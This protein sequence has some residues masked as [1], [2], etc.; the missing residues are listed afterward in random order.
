M[1]IHKI[2]ARLESR[3]QIAEGL[4]I[5]LFSL[6]EDFHFKPGQYATL[7]LTHRGKTLP[8]PYSIASSPAQSRKLE[9]YLN[10][11]EDGRLTPSLWDPEVLNDLHN[12]H[13]ET[14]VAISGPHGRFVLDPDDPRDLV[15]VASGTGVA[16]FVSMLRDLREA[17]LT[18]LRSFRRRRVYLVHGVSFS[19]HLAYR[20]EFEQ[21]ALET[22]RDPEVG[23]ALVYLP[24]ISRPHS[25]PGWTGL[26]GR[27]ETIIEPR[28]DKGDVSPLGLQDAIK[29]MIGTLL[30][31]E[32]HV[33]YV[34]GHPGT[35]DRVMQLLSARGF[36]PDAD[37]KREKYYS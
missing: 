21:M 13:S 14:H 19:S 15:F 8:R 16:P 32:T 26:K 22:M 5:F 23:L 33:V 11:V 24:T 37:L 25:D 36:K 35:V 29:A 1:T 27:A 9:F 34:C 28:S 17:S 3:R 20:A 31:P 4:A 12:F 6:S 30:S 2:E 10:L 18:D 7:W